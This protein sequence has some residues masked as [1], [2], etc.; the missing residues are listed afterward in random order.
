M[1]LWY[2]F[3]PGIAETSAYRVFGPYTGF[4]L[5]GIFHDG[6]AYGKHIPVY[7]D[8]WIECLGDLA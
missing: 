4:D 2:P 8:T 1:V 7:K 3:V 5:Y 6:S